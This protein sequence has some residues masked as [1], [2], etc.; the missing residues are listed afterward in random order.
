MSTMGKKKGR[1][2]KRGRRKN[3]KEGLLMG[4]GLHKQTVELINFIKENILK[5]DKK[6]I[7]RI[8]YALE[9]LQ[10]V[11]SSDEAYQKVSYACKMARFHGLIHPEQLLLDKARQSRSFAEDTALAPH[12]L[13]RLSWRA[14]GYHVNYWDVKDEYI[15]VWQEKESM[16]PEFFKIC[17]DYNVRLETAKGD[18]SITAIWFAMK[19]LD[20]FLSTDKKIILLYFGDFNPSGLH[21]P[22]A[23]QNTM[24]KLRAA[25][26]NEF[27]NDFSQIEFK[28]IA[29]NHEHLDK[30]QLPE[31]PTKKKTIKDKSIAEKFIRKYGD[32]NVEME[33][34]AERQPEEM[35]KL[36]VSAISEYVDE[37]DRA[38]LKDRMTK[39]RWRLKKIYDEMIK[40][41]F[42]EKWNMEYP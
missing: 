35:K 26:K 5:D 32:R 16:E 39:V 41:Y 17:N 6:S 2:R 8:Y 4:R 7:R 31:N 10:M 1:K 38:K 3:P 37:E 42:K 40:I 23:I 12:L 29:L 24:R 30:Y 36:I 28:R 33:S 13:E 15:E 21:S 34:L 14:F 11:E 25:W 9:A 19:R 18:Q 27:K 22:I 20:L